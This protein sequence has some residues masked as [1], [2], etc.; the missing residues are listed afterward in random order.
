M[1]I[2][3]HSTDIMDGCGYIDEKISMVSIS[4]NMQYYKDTVL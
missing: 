2:K 4:H 3:K 1:K